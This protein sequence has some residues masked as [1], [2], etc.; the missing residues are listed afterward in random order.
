MFKLFDNTEVSVPDLT[1]E[2]FS[3]QHS[4]MSVVSTEAIEDFFYK[5]KDVF[6]STKDRL[7]NS[8]IEKVAIDATSSKYEVT[9]ITKRVPF[10]DVAY[11]I[12]TTPERFKGQYTNYVKDLISVSN[13]MIPD[14][15]KLLETLKMA[16][17]SFINEY[18][19]NGVLSIYGVAYGKTLEDKRLAKLK[20]ISKYFP[21][22]KT[23]SKANVKDVIRNNNDLLSIYSDV[24]KLSSLVSEDHLKQLTKLSKEVSE[25]VDVLIEQNSSSGILINNSEAKK[26]LVTLIQTG[27]SSVEFCGYLY[28]NSL[29]F[30]TSV[31]SLGDVYIRAGNR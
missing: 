7:F 24:P 25:M 11:E 4:K 5:T 26:D 23:T 16:V 8:E 19:S 30:Y 9:N 12:V 22:T 29:Q 20:L 18:S 10:K 27:A 17:A 3:E 13:E 6:S 15:I 2:E 14:T 1:I 28:A 21:N 31:K